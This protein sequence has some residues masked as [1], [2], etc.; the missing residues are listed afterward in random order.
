M[1]ISP[2]LV[3]QKKFENFQKNFTETLDNAEI[4]LY[5]DLTELKKGVVPSM[6]NLFNL[7]NRK[8][9]RKSTPS[10]LVTYTMDG[11]TYTVPATTAGLLCM[12]ADP[13]VEIVKVASI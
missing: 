3:N 10:V 6:F 8:T 1:T 13:C 5:N 11:E 7:F 9:A 12:D 2:V 4:M